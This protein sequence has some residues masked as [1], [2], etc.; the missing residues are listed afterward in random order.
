MVACQFRGFLLC[1]PRLRPRQVLRVND[2]EVDIKFHHP[3]LKRAA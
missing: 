1:R 3:A 2:R